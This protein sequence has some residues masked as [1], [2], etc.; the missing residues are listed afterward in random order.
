MYDRTVGDFNGEVTAQ[1]EDVTT[2]IRL[3]E[4]KYGFIP[5]SRL[6]ETL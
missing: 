4:D 3:L 2:E 6:G 5:I 1:A